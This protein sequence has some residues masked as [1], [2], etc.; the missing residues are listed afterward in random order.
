MARSDTDSSAENRP[1]IEDIRLLGRLLGDVVREC[2]G[3]EGFDTV[4]QIRQLSVAVR[5]GQ[6]EADGRRLDVLLK[7][8]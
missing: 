7:R 5:L 1:L 3:K 2:E 6:D 4:E 8:L